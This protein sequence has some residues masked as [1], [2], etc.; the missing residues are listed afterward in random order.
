MTSG[1]TRS[2]RV[3]E[4]GRKLHKEVVIHTH[5]NHPHEITGIT[6]EA[7][8]RLVERGIIVRNQTVLQREAS[9]T[10]PRR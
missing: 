8:D 6:R 4:Q 5:F 3:V 2:P 10:A 9:T 1:S 7:M